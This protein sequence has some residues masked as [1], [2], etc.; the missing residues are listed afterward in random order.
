VAIKKDNPETKKN[1][2]KTQHR[3]LNT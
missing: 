3:Q 2:T 1:K